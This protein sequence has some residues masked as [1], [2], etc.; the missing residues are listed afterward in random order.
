[1]CF[2][3]HIAL[4]QLIINLTSNIETGDTLQETPPEYYQQFCPLVPINTPLTILVIQIPHQGKTCWKP[5]A[6]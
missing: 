5:S 1:M 4:Y 2:V 6:Q 3:F